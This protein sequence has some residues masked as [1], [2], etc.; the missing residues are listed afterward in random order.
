LELAG[1]MSALATASSRVAI[2]NNSTASGLVVAGT[3]QRV[4]GI[5][6]AGD[7]HIAAGAD[8][9]VDHLIQNALVIGGDESTPA[10]VTISASDTSGSPL[11]ANDSNLLGTSPSRP[12]FAGD[13]LVGGPTL[14]SSSELFSTAGFTAFGSAKSLSVPEPSSLALVVVILATALVGFGFARPR[15]APAQAG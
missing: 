8:L 15:A 6:G 12:A 13:G 9:T 5:D 2:L 10:L 14:S 11:A 4:G 1:S 7:V 3:D